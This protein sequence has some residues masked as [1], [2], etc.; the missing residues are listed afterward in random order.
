M[1]KMKVGIPDVSIGHW[2]DAVAQTGCTAVLLPKGTTAS[3]E[4]RGGAPAARETDALRPDKAVQSIDGICLSGGSA[5]GLAAADGVM[6]F[7]EE[8]GRGVATPG[9][10]VPIVPAMSLF[11]LA[12]GNGAVRP[13]SENGYSAARDAIP[14]EVVVGRVGAGTGAY[15]GHRHGVAGRRPG[16]LTYAEES[17]SGVIVGALVAV[18]AF[19]D[20]EASADFIR[21]EALGS[22]FEYQQPA[23]MSRQHTTIGVVITNALL[24]KVD[25]L[26][27]A[28]GAHDGLSRSISPPHTRYDGD[29]FIAAATGQVK[30]D[31]DLVRWLALQAVNSS[32]RSLCSAS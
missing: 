13:T 20:V 12:V 31:V 1:N 5:F 18:N 3:I 24:S 30:A 25:C 4:M 15:V 21:A 10:V 14:G 11:D 2:T 26:I 17:I 9:G 6:R 7:L 23:S 19:G 27:V 29:G 32:I 8:Q 22:P 16:G 28:Q